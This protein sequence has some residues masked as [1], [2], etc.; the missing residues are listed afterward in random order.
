MSNTFKKKK[1][2]I[3]ISLVYKFFYTKNSHLRDVN[4]FSFDFLFL[5]RHKANSFIILI[6]MLINIILRACV[7]VELPMYTIVNEKLW[8]LH[9][10]KVKKKNNENLGVSVR[11]LNFSFSF[12]PT[13]S[14][15][16]FHWV[17]KNITVL[18]ISLA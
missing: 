12:D 13:R 14:L 7:C 11:P 2:W 6:V 1:D 16:G 8:I 17:N 18:L 10:C 9:T 4:I 15:N 3:S 5:I